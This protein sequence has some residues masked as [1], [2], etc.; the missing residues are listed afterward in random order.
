MKFTV[1][2][3]KQY[4]DFELPP[5]ELADRLTMLGLEV[6]AVD[7]LY[8]GLEQIRVAKVVDVLKHPNAD[9]LHLC[10]VDVGG[11]VKRV[12]CGA[13]NVASG[14]LTPIALPGCT[15][16]G[17]TVKKAKIRGEASEGMLCSEKEL[18]LSAEH[19][20]IMEL[21]E[22]CVPG[23][24]LTEA[25][26]LDDTLIEVDLTPNRPDCTSVIG[27]AREVAGMAGTSLKNTIP[28][29]LPVLTGSAFFAVDVQSPDACPRYAARLLRNVTIRESPWWLKRILLAV[30]LRPIN[31]VVDITNY[32]MLEYGQPLHAF[33][34]NL[35]ADKKIIVRKAVDGEKMLTLDG[36]ERT[37]DD[38]M[39]LI[40]DGQKPVAVAG[41]MGGGNSEVSDTTTDILLESAYFNPISVRRTSSV[42]KLSTDASY[43][44]ER[45]VDPQGTIIALERAA[46]LIVDLAGA[47][48]EDGGCDCLTEI[49]ETATIE[50]RVNKVNDLLGTDLSLD[51]IASFLNGIEIPVKIKDTQTLD[52]TPP[53]FRVDLEREIDLVEEIARLRGYNEIATTLPSVPMSF[54]EE[55]DIRRLRKKLTDIMVSLGM[56][57]CVNYSFISS[58]HYDMLQLAS[59][60]TLRN[61]V[62][63]LNPLTEDQAV[64]RTTLLPGLLENLRHNINRQTTEVA[65]FEIGKV[66]LP[67]SGQELP[68]EIT[69][70][71][72]VF[73]GRRDPGASHYHYGVE[74][75]ALLDVKGKVETILNALRFCSV[76]FSKSETVPSHSDQAETLAVSVAGLHVG[77]I[78]KLSQ[79]CL[80][81]FGVKQDVFFL[82]LDLTTLAGVDLAAPVFTPISKYPFVQW[83]LALIVPDSVGAGHITETIMGEGLPL[84][85]GVEIFDVYSGKPIEDGH[86]S[87]ALSITYHSDE[88]T[89]D[90]EKVAEIHKLIIDLI[91]ARF[92]GKLREI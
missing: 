43:R 11:E 26:N 23:Q 53:S 50:L 76:Q 89:L 7:T 5:D 61:S 60:D 86:K 2:W 87:V 57:E 15:I 51:E 55:D 19:A 21:P 36:V 85:K 77:I 38:Q 80:K 90:D 27:I 73:S 20:G 3:L 13:P 66:F 69:R 37:L 28:A 70:V 83:D 42:L 41:V 64:M 46:Q 35:I 82:D 31:N 8:N 58:K 12:V 62:Q 49:A 67:Q 34:F 33:D 72:S 54:S 45:G 47:Q 25:L 18:G 91:A 68:D 84:V 59:G 1:D 56:Y 92:G 44:F 16:S 6:D 17:F 65:M 71:C 48:L 39:L 52:V 75:V 74:S 88:Q 81:S 10:N 29:D 14:M 30:G 4:V 9:K 63:I 22:T 32:V 79:A 78:G 40:C 24:L